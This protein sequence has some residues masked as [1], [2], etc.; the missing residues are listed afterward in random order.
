MDIAAAYAS[1]VDSPVVAAIVADKESVIR[2]WNEGAEN[3]FG[4]SGDESVGQSLSLIIPDRFSA[5][6]HAGMEAFLKSRV[7][8]VIGK[9]VVHLPARHKS[10]GEITVRI[11]LSHWRDGDQDYFTALCSD[12]SD[13]QAEAD[14]K[15]LLAEEMAH[16]LRNLM[17][18]VSVLVKKTLRTS[19]TIED[20][21]KVVDQRI[22]AL[23][24][25]L[26][27]LVDHQSILVKEVEFSAIV[28]TALNHV[29]KPYKLMGP[30]MILNVSDATNM[31]L[32]FHELSTNCVKYGAWSSSTGEVEI[33][34]TEDDDNLSLLW[35]EKGGPVVAPPSRQGFG[36]ILINK[37]A[38]GWHNERRYD[39][40]GFQC[41]FT[42]AKAKP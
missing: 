30:P 27:L 25:T 18:M 13:F 9:Q 8:K 20:A 15:K 33:T 42:K 5:A 7:G 35:E 29:D 3:L 40:E 38:V 2:L 17:S 24:K 32:I 4:W 12:Y 21:Q 37:L 1:V 39:P 11:T 41:R 14:R 22:A 28:A 16:R 36:T 26:D 19:E 34:V 23:G 10:G 6:H 31:S